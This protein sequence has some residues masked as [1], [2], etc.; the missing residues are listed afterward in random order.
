MSVYSNP[1]R[2]VAASRLPGRV[3]RQILNQ[4]LLLNPFQGVLDLRGALTQ[5]GFTPAC[6][7]L[8]LLLFTLQAGLA[9]LEAAARVFGFVALRLQHP[10]DLLGFLECC[11]QRNPA[12]ADG[13]AATTLDAVE[14][15][16]IQRARPLPGVNLPVQLL[17]Q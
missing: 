7:L 6:G 2:L 10:R 16:L 3:G 12:W 17:R 9:G 14:Q 5:P 11:G 8:T 13:V 15:V 1:S 4:A